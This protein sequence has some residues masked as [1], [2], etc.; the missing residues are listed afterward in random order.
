[1]SY[2]IV[3]KKPDGSVSYSI[4]HADTVPDLMKDT[5]Q[6]VHAIKLTLE[7]SLLTKYDIVNKFRNGILR[8]DK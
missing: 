5:N 1:M 6:V 8:E 3:A 2:L 4:L 7:D